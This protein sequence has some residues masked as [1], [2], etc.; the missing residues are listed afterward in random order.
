LT[1][2]T[3]AAALATGLAALAAVGCRTG[4]EQEA[5]AR[6]ARLSKAIDTVRDAPNEAKH[7]S[8][9][10]LEEV[11]C[12]KDQYCAL[13]KTCVEAYTLHARA[14]DVIA[15]A[16]EDLTAQGAVTTESAL[17]LLQGAERDIARSVEL[18]KVCADEQGKMIRAEG[19]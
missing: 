13:K 19:L 3:T 17:A 7:A 2:S 6:A 15:S 8:L 9:D 12:G 18:A 16:R 14:I 10:A 5:R 4:D 1:G 11:P